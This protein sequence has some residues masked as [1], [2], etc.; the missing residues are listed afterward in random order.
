MEDG[1]EPDLSGMDMAE[2]Q[3]LMVRGREDRRVPWGEK[4]EK[5]VARA[6]AQDFFY[7]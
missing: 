6:P 2:L 7:S 5:K 4:E 1:D 3:K